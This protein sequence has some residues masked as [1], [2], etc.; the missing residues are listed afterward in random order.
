MPEDSIRSTE[1][2]HI[3]GK[4]IIL[5]VHPLVEAFGSCEP[6][7]QDS[8]VILVSADVWLNE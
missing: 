1:Y 5:I 7:D 4:Q 3:E 6:E 8:G 2:H